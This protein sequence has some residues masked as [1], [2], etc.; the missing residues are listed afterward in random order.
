MIYRSTKRKP[1][2]AGAPKRKLEDM[3]FWSLIHILDAEYSFNL[4]AGTAAAQ[5]HPFVKCYTCGKQ[6]HWKDTD[7]GHYEQREM[8]GTRYD[9]RNTRIQC[10]TCNRMNEGRKAVFG[11]RLRNDGIDVDS[12]RTLAA[13]WGKTRPP[14][15]TLIEQIKS[16]RAENKRIR[17]RIKGM[18]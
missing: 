7:C 5:G 2:P 9:V 18:E 10:H 6:D 12:V 1:R 3:D 17:E 16:Y 4:R 14:L 8:M 13:M 11:D 15:E